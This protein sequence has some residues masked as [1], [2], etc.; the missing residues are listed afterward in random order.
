[1]NRPKL[2]DHYI[3]EPETANMGAEVTIANMSEG[4][5]YCI[6]MKTFWFVQSI[7][8]NNPELWKKIQRRAKEMEEQKCTEPLPTSS[9]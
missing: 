9:R 5:R 4:G 6:G 7:R 3:L 8:R 2:A 1:M